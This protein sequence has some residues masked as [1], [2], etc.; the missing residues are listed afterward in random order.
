MKVLGI[1][2]AWDSGAALLVDGVVVAAANE[3][4]FSRIKLDRCFPERSIGYVLAS[5]VGLDL[6]E[7]DRCLRYSG[8]QRRRQFPP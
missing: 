1:A 4:R 8:G 3:E 5:G 6:L 2:N 7:G